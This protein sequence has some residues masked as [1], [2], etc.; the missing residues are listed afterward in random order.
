MTMNDKPLG[1]ESFEW[2]ASIDKRNV[3]DEKPITKRGF[4]NT[5]GRFVN[6]DKLVPTKPWQSGD[7]FVVGKTKGDVTFPLGNSYKTVPFN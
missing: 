2:R 6:A 5:S 3:S 1:T 7:V 4:I